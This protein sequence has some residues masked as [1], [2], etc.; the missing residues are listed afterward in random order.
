MAEESAAGEVGGSARGRREG[1]Q[2]AGVCAGWW[3]QV[4]FCGVDG[5][6]IRLGSHHQELRTLP[7]GALTLPP[8]QPPLHRATDRHEY[9][10]PIMPLLQPP[11]PP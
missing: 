5:Q 2:P 1:A 4:L 6:E 10:P 8:A 9:H 3:E 11:P 7:S